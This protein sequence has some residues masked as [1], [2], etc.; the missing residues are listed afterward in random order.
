MMS[1]KVSKNVSVLSAVQSYS[2]GCNC[3]VNPRDHVVLEASL[4]GNNICRLWVVSLF[5][6]ELMHG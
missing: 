5:V 1:C 2:Q 3:K 6:T 4:D